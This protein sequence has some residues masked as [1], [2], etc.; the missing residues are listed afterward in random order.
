MVGRLITFLL[1]QKAHFQVRAVSFREGIL[2]LLNLCFV[3]LLLLLLLGFQRQALGAKCL[4]DLRGVLPFLGS[5]PP[6]PRM[7]PWQLSQ[8]SAGF[9]GNLV[10]GARSK[11]FAKSLEVAFFFQ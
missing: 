2:L 9:C 7:Q 1:G 4:R 6:P 3:L 8:F 11:R 10:L 5:A